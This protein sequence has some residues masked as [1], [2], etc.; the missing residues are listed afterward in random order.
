M[1]T[2]RTFESFYNYCDIRTVSDCFLDLEDDGFNVTISDESDSFY[3]KYLIRIGKQSKLP[4]IILFSAKDVSETILFTLSYLEGE[5][6]LKL[7]TIEI[8][9]LP[10]NTHLIPNKIDTKRIIDSGFNTEISRPDGTMY[11]FDEIC[12]LW[13]EISNEND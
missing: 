3:T 2:I 12:R 13:L 9:D 10:N 6:G 4:K 1:K 7:K 8:L 11:N 5:C